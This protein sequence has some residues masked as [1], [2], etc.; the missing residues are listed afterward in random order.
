MIL[1][2]LLLAIAFAL[3]PLAAEIERSTER[4]VRTALSRAGH[5]WVTVDASGQTVTLSGTPPTA[6]A[7]RRAI[8][9]AQDARTATWAGP[10]VPA[11]AVR[12]GFGEP[13]APARVEPSPE[14]TFRL[15]DGVLELEGAVPDASIRST[16]EVAASAAVDPPRIAVV[17]NQ[18]EVVDR[19]VPDG[20]VAVAERGLTNLV[21]CDQGVA[22]FACERYSLVCELPESRAEAVRASALAPLPLGHLGDIEVLANESVASCEQGLAEVLRRSTI[23]FD[24]ESDE[25]DPRSAPLLDAVADAARTCPGTLRIEGHSDDTGDPAFN[26]ALSRRRAASVRRALVARGIAPSRLEAQGY[27][28]RAPVAENR[29][30]AGRSRNRRIEIRVVGVAD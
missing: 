15:E 14:W 21:Q 6:D 8:E 27:G 22:S 4:T 9:V 19:P 28:A 12:D 5:R 2:T 13:E 3:G 25:I 24:S 29:T 23:R 30:P 16:L 26:D 17:H 7:G 18:L 20:F 11:T 10:L 1:G